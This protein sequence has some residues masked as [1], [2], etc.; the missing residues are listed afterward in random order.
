MG[1]KG[2]PS[3]L[4]V[5]RHAESRRNVTKKGA[6]YFANEEARSTVKGIPDHKVDLTE[7]GVEQARR[8]GV[9]L[10]ERY[11][12]FD[13][14]YHS[15]YLRAERTADLILAA[16]T[17]EERARTKKV[18]NT[19]IRERHTGYAYDMTVEE[20]ERY[21]PWME[22]YW[23]TFGP[24]HGTPIGGESI[25]SVVDRAYL[26][27]GMV[28]R[29]HRGKKVCIV[30]HGHCI[31]CIRYKLERWTDDDAVAWKPGEEPENCSLLLYEPDELGKIVLKEC[32]TVY[33]R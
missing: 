33:W 20:V 16:Y 14:I 26:F 5:V 12:V 17:D 13:Y 32:N 19:F 24:F 3:Q 28:R 22:E 2:W 23:A 27:I 18:A 15:G 6:R 7:L 8:T 9:A 25:I 11:G 21:F 4:V 29:K 30:S 1:K 10:R 31:R